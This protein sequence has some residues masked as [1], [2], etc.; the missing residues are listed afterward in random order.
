MTDYIEKLT[1]VRDLVTIGYSLPEAFMT[2]GI[3]IHDPVVSL[4]AEAAGIDDERPEV[5]L[6]RMGNDE[7]CAAVARALRKQQTGGKS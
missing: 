2:A 6:V 5:T 1:K 7:A 4:V 3:G